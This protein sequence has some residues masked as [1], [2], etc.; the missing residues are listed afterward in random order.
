M[1]LRAEKISWAVRGKPLLA[2]VTLDA[3]AG[4]L[5]GLL[6]PNGSGKSSLLRVLAGLQRPDTGRVL[7]DGVDTRSMPRRALARTLALVTQHTAADVDMSVRDVLLLA[8]I[9]HRP[10]LAATTAAEVA[11]AEQ[12]LA[13]AGLAGFAD[14]RW[15]TLSGGERQ[16]VDI[17]RALLQQPQVLLL[18]EPTNHLDIRHQ[19]E[20]LHRLAREPVTVVTAL[21]DLNL[22]ARFCD[23]IVLLHAGRVMAAGPP[24]QVL[25][26]ARIAEVYQVTADIDVDPVGHTRVH[27]RQSIESVHSG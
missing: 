6:G 12:A 3:P 20:L 11:A 5:V 15:S 14:R 19:L 4:T 1:R 23:Q 25:T 21:H 13:D 7:L 10:L 2:D 18:D 16:R 8:R 24:A 26:P 22:A 9:P 17:A 27:L